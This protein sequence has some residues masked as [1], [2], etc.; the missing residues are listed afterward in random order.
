MA[1]MV[2]LSSMANDIRAG[3][4]LTFT[5][6]R[7][8]TLMHIRKMFVCSPMSF[9]LTVRQ[10]AKD[11]QF[12]VPSRGKLPNPR[13]RTPGRRRLRQSFFVSHVD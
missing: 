6:D 10:R 3:G 11:L 9:S 13:Q 8:L 5:R 1:L 2:R 7:R 4:Q 12:I